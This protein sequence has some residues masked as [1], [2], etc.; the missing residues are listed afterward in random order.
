MLFY[1]CFQG[2]PSVLGS[3][4]VCSLLGR[5]CPAL[6]ILWVPVVLR[7]GLPHLSM[8]TAVLVQILL[9]QSC[10]WA[11]MGVAS[12]I[13][14]RHSL[15]ANSWIF[16]LLQSFCPTSAEVSLSLRWG[17]CVVA[18]SVGTGLHKLAFWLLVVFCYGLLLLKSKVS[19]MRSE[20]SLPFPVGIR[21]NI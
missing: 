13:P 8:S 18:V 15:T 20:D 12:D 5:V 14:R 4:R 17:C 6:T 10:W 3:Q 11:F 2:P 7:V 19:L 16:W 9:R 1:A 21:T